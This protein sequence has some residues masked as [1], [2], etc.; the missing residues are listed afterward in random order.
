MVRDTG[1]HPVLRLLKN[2]PDTTI[3]RGEAYPINYKLCTGGLF[4]QSH[5]MCGMLI[6]AKHEPF[7]LQTMEAHDGHAK[8]TR[9]AWQPL[10]LGREGPAAVKLS[11]RR[12]GAAGAAGGLEP[13][14]RAY[15]LAHWLRHPD[16]HAG[17]ALPRPGMGALQS[18]ACPFPDRG[19]L[20]RV[21]AAV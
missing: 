2:Y 19:A 9:H 5:G 8:A 14:H 11:L 12:A 1:N 20:G 3:C 21:R 18:Q 15:P 10:Q 7:S 4:Q 16:V 13:E 17:R 6:R